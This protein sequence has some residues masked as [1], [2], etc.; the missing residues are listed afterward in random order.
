MVSVRGIVVHS[1]LAADL[2]A[3]LAAAEADG[4]TLRGGGY[5]NPAQQRWLREQ[6]CPDPEHSP[7]SECHP[8]TARPGQSLHEDGLA[9]DFTLDG[10]VITSRSSPGF[11]WLDANAGR[12][13]LKNLPSEPWHWSTTGG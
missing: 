11:R 7:A 1:S 6:H 3:L 2:E 12:F 4:I 8:P 13:G 10:A 9:I 5:R